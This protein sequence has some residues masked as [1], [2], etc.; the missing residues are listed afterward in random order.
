MSIKNSFNEINIFNTFVRMKNKT[1]HIKNMVCPRC[2]AAVEDLL[3]S[4]DIVYSDIK[5]GEVNLKT[6]IS[7]IN[8]QALKEKL[9]LLGFEL[10]DDNNSKIVSQIKSEIINYI[11]FSPNE[12]KKYNFSEYIETKIGMS[13]SSLSRLFSSVEALTIEK[14]VISQKIERVKEFIIYDELSLSEI[15]YMLDYSS[16]QHLSKQFK[17]ITGMTPTQFKKLEI[18]NRKSLDK[19]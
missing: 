17:S 11:H 4:M 1:L 3:Q 19:I 10:I 9:K 6:K 15:S 16:V 5:L 12:I 8:I 18:K 14:Y 7:D 13:Y 2:I